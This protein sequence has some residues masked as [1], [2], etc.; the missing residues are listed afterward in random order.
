MLPL[1]IRF[2]GVILLVGILV[3]LYRKFSF[4]KRCPACGY[5]DPNRVPRRGI[6]KQL[7][8]KAYVC[9]RCRNHFYKV[10]LLTEDPYDHSLV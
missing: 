3:A 9:T 4:R 6:Y 1:V 5:D 7:P 8:V 2:V 10:Q